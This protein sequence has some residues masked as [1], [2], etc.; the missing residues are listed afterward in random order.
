M[1]ALI[2]Q[3]W[4]EQA[5]RNLSGST[6]KTDKLL[7]DTILRDIAS[8][9]M[10][11]G[12]G[13][14]RGYLLRDAQTAFTADDYLA[15][16]GGPPKRMKGE[17]KNQW[18]DRSE[19][20]T[21]QAK[22]YAQEIFSSDFEKRREAL[23]SEQVG[24][25][26]ALA[27]TISNAKKAFEAARSAAYAEK[28]ANLPTQQGGGTRRTT[29]TTTGMTMDTTDDTTADT[30]TEGTVAPDI[31]GGPP[32]GAQTLEYTTGEEQKVGFLTPSG[33]GEESFF[34]KNKLWIGLGSVALIGGGYWW[35]TQKYLPTKAGR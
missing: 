8:A 29:D 28:T 35:Y 7:T 11:S 32:S 9:G 13:I 31:T 17:T 19:R 6:R 23:R 5:F 30:M 24:A 33:A 15:A 4:Y 14:S 2:D 10:T 16:L 20:W 25:R 22:S 21:R 34:S 26:S 3:G 27:S 18:Y 12:V 1:Y